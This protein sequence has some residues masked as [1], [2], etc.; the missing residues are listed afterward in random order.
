MRPAVAELVGPHFRAKGEATFEVV[1]EPDPSGGFAVDL[2]A[3]GD[4][5]EGE[6]RLAVA[7]CKE[8]HDVVA[9]LV[10]IA[11]DPEAALRTGV[12]APQAWTTPEPGLHPWGAILGVGAVLDTHSLP[13]VT[14]APELRLAWDLGL[15]RAGVRARV[16]L[17]RTA[18][19]TLAM[20]ASTAEVSVTLWSGIAEACAMARWTAFAVGPCAGAEAGL[21]HG[22]G[23][24]DGVH[25]ARSAG[26]AWFAATVGGELDLK[27]S[28][29]V[30][31]DLQ[32][33][34]ALPLLRT[35]FAV[36]PDQELHVT[37]PLGFRAGLGVVFRLPP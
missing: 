20:T 24:G 28:D 16:Y 7:S 15:L 30:G 19:R 22:D 5:V 26:N 34:A 6:R 36:R 10:A 8:A 11:L 37:D 33:G 13:G 21:L 3:D 27:L 17:P 4:E 31:L 35:R 25:M 14:V 32:L 23:G 12:E 29:V 18:E 1:L 9:V 2:R